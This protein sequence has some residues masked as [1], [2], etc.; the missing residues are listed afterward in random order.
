[1]SRTPASQSREAVLSQLKKLHRPLE[2]HWSIQGFLDPEGSDICYKNHLARLQS[3][4]A[5]HK[6]DVDGP[7]SQVNMSPM[8]LMYG[9][10]G[11][12]TSEGGPKKEKKIQAREAGWVENH[13][14]YSALSPEKTLV[15]QSRSSHGRAVSKRAAEE[16]AELE[17][18]MANAN[19]RC[20]EDIS[21]EELIMLG[22]YKLDDQQKQVYDA[23][24]EMLR[25]FDGH[26]MVGS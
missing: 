13:Q 8:T 22:L 19:H 2:E 6:F 23:F 12:L 7:P 26:D 16:K 9:R 15:R 25:G 17:E 1:M 24:A 21:K 3:I 4:Y 10:Q 18:Q 20:D 11:L 14:K 5:H